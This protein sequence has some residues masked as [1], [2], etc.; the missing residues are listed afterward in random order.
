M[1]SSNFIAA[2]A[3]RKNTN[4]AGGAQTIFGTMFKTPVLWWVPCFMPALGTN[5]MTY[6]ALTISSL[7]E[8]HA[9]TATRLSLP[10]ASPQTAG[11]CTCPA[12]P[13]AVAV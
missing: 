8:Q 3:H 13:A 11:S 6:L 7:H 5:S 2:G 9:D 12:V 10:E 1:T 4:R